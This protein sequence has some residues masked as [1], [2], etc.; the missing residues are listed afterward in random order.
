MKFVI[1]KDWISKKK[2]ESNKSLLV[3]WIF[4]ENKLKEKVRYD[5]WDLKRSITTRQIQPNLVRVWSNKVQAYIEEVWRKP[6]RFPNMNALVWWAWRHGMISW[7]KTQ[8]YDSLTSKDKSVVFLLARA[9][10]IRWIKAKR[11]FSKVWE[12]NKTQ[13]VRIYLDNMKKWTI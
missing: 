1:N 5:T 4:I 10:S 8:W 13:A 6:W 12:E 7:K 9:I 3:A 2:V 11:T